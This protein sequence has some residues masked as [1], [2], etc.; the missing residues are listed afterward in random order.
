MKENSNLSKKNIRKSFVMQNEQTDCGVAC[1]LSLIR[2]YGGAA[3]LEKLRNA[4][5]T[6][7]K[8]TTLLGLYQAAQQIGFDSNG[9]EADINSLIEHARPVILHIV[10]EN[11]NNHYVV[12]YGVLENKFIIGD[13]GKGVSY[14]TN[15]ELNKIWKTKKCLTLLP[16]K[17]FVKANMQ[18]S[19]KRKWIENLLKED[20]QLLIFSTILGSCIAFLGMAM[21]VFSQKLIDEILPS[22]NMKKLFWGIGLLIF[23]LFMRSGLDALR[24][25]FLVYQSQRF[26]KRI[27]DK[28]YTSLLSLPKSFFDTRK[29]GELT[30]RLMDTQRVQRVITVIAGNSIIEFLTVIASF[31]FLFYYSW[32]TGLIALIAVPIYFLLI[33]AFNKR[34]ILAQHEIMQSYAMTESNFITTMQGIAEIKNNNRKPFFAKINK[35]IY[36]NYQDKN[37]SLGKV[38][39]KLSFLSGIVGI[40]ILVS[41]LM[42]ASL[43]VLNEQLLLG[44]LLALVGISGTLLPAIAN[45]ALI[46]VPINEAKIAFHRMYEFASLK[47]EDEGNVQISTIESVSVK[48]L[49]FRFAGQKQ[50]LRSLSFDIRKG[51]C[52]G[53]IGESGC[54]KSTLLQILQKFYTFESGCILINEAI[55]L[56]IANTEDWRKLIGVIPQEVAIFSGTLLDNILLGEKFDK[57][58]VENFVTKYGF[59]TFIKELPQGYATLLGEGGINLSAGQ[60]QLLGLMRVLYRK[61]SLLILDEFTSGMDRKM[62][63]FSLKILNCI[64]TEVAIIFVSH[65]LLTLKDITDR[66]YILEEGVISSFGSHEELMASSNFYSVFWNILENKT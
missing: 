8:G 64:K 17:S 31:L 12:C 60:M 33:Y 53:I 2:Y 62:E 16:N 26:N 4:S 58:E 56:D 29:I 28:F 66:I 34:I 49:S 6:N 48:N 39:I 24:N 21:S 54:G 52:I 44:K 11:V 18:K 43:Q 55:K 3:S 38:N 13:P 51:E 20:I 47:P 59:S 15:D 63:A 22:G 27:T 23:L 40:L 61:P 45:L 42:H 32:Q 65:R 41:I 36:G 25:L 10:K 50:L 35:I 30:A 1:L 57:T 46:A 9:C 7:V 19:L 5:G 37:V 14:Y